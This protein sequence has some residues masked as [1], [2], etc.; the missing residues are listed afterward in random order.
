MRLPTNC[1]TRES[2]FFVLLLLLLLCFFF[3]KDIENERDG[4]R[5]SFVRVNMA[6]CCSCVRSAST[7]PQPVAEGETTG[8][9]PDLSTVVKVFMDG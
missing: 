2:I 9:L 6:L 7:I 8:E 4:S 3:D 5:S 1:H